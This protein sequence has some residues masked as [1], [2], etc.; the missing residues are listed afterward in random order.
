MKENH[1]G[2]GHTRCGSALLGSDYYYSNRW[3][4]GSSSAT[5][6]KILPL[7]QLLIIIPQ[8]VKGMVVSYCVLT[9]CPL[10]EVAGHSETWWGY[11]DA[12]FACWSERW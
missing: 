8:A 3:A 6:L 7:C 1:E 10:V 11:S 2:G 4:M 5:I 12:L 9:G